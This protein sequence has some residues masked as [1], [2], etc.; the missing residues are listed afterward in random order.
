MQSLQKLEKLDISGN[1]FTNLSSSVYTLSN[2]KHLDISKNR[3]LKSLDSKILQLTQLHTLIIKD[4]VA[5]TS[6]PLDVCERGLV[7]VRQYYYNN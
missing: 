4:C 6:P 7:A 1:L 2:L 5:L 3:L